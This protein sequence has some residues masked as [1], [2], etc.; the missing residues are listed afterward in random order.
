MNIPPTRGC[1]S[2]LGVLLDHGDISLDGLLAVL[3]LPSLGS[4]GEGLLLG[5]VPAS[6]ESSLGLVGDVVGPDG[7]Q[8]S[9]Y[10][11][12]SCGKGVTLM[13]RGPSGVSM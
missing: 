10:R 9:S 13:D 1:Y 11:I 12:A 3:G 2:Y 8:N 6:V 7:L 5:A 4:L